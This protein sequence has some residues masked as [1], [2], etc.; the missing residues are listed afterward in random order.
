M[1]ALRAC[2]DYCLSVAPLF[3]HAM[4]VSNI[5]LPQEFWDIANVGGYYLDPAYKDHR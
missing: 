5:Y 2:D 1:G 3:A 4:N